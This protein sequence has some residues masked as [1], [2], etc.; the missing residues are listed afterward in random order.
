MPSPERHPPEPPQR[1]GPFAPATSA[2]AD[3]LRRATMEL[4]VDR[5][6]EGVTIEMALARAR[7]SAADLHP[8]LAD[9][10]DLCTRIYI[11]NVEEFDR[12]VFG[13][14]ERSSGWPERLRASAYAALRYVAARPTEARFNFIHALS[15]G[16]AA[17]A[18]RDRYVRRIVEL[19]DEG[20]AVAPDPAAIGPRTAEAT[21]GSIY[22]FLSKRIGEG[23]D[24][25][26]L[27]HFAPELMCLAVRPYLGH[28][29]AMAELR[30]PPPPP[31]EER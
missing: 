2:A 8:P 26:D 24:V 21:F 31:E 9:L 18:Y 5:G 20:R 30:I 13:A 23:E 7:A 1:T 6:Q 15:A 29:A 4:V 16:D 25:A 19:I 12:I 10:P 3:R 17:A 11:A 28:E 22:E 27:E 14:V